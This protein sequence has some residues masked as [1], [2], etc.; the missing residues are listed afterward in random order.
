MSHD[1]ISM[2]LKATES[3]EEVESYLIL[4]EEEG[5][6]EAIPAYSQSPNLD[7]PILEKVKK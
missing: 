1:N 7:F 2:L 3:S 6:P 5:V 4:L